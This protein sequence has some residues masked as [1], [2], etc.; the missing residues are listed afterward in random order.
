MFRGAVD[1]GGG[2][3]TVDFAHFGADKISNFIGFGTIVLADGGPNTLTLNDASF[4][5]V[6]GGSIT[7]V[8]GNAGNTIDAS[9]LT[10]S[11]RVVLFGG[12]GNDVFKFSA[13]S[14]LATD[15]VTGGSGADTLAMTTAGAVRAG[16]VSG[17]ETFALASGGANS[18][19]LANAN[20]IISDPGASITVYGG[21]KGNT[22]NASG[23][24][25]THRVV[26]V[27][28]AG[29]DV[30]TG[31]AG[32]DIFKFS[33]ASLAATDMVK[34]GL[35]SD[36]LVMTTAG[37]VAAAGVGGVEAYVLAGGAADILTLTSA[38]FTGVTGAS[39]TVD[40]GNAGNTVDATAETAATAPANR[41][42]A[43]GGAGKDVF[44]GGAGNDIFK[45]AAAALG[46]A[47]TV[48][49]GS[50]SDEL[51][52]TTAGTIAT[53]GV[54]GVES[55]VL[56]GGAA[57]TLTLKA[58][59]FT[60]V[61][62]GAI[63]IVD[64]GGGTTVNASAEPTA[65][66]VVVH[67]G[68][69]VDKL[70]GGA[71]GD[72]FFAGGKTVMTGKTGRNQ[73]VFSAPGGNTIADFAVSSTNEIAFGNA[74]FK[75]HLSGAAASPKPLPASLFTENSTGAFTKT[76]Q[77]FAYDTTN[78]KLFFSASGTT[79]TEHLVVTLAGDPTLTASHLFFVT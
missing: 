18:L 77:R 73:F 27:G 70:T 20:F 53:A 61:T 24:T 34:G 42:V 5:G 38:N 33:A 59:N 29:R 79:A 23:L 2:A 45:F 19:T 74:G 28:G 15:L 4:A 8:G 51:L 64:G 25:G 26:A 13:A 55:C 17:V 7:V 9:A 32:N 44:T 22:I 40:G 75:L 43:V 10:G 68:S 50:G 36:E 78:G 63:T 11:N 65:D 71:G 14:L 52:L 47:D 35:G 56:A 30:F 39:I 49:G 6:D 3:D 58:G 12:A 16:G 21:A 31:G 48:V 76:T 60:G 46:A 57:N 66:H 41:V 72:V 69:G 67:A 62:G 37:A 54:R 1:G